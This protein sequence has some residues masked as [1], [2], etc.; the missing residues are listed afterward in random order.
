[1]NIIIELLTYFTLSVE[2]KTG[3]TV[4]GY[5]CTNKTKDM[6]HLVITNYQSI[7]CYSMT[8]RAHP[9]RPSKYFQPLPHI[10][11]A[12][13]WPLFES[14][15]TPWLLVFRAAPLCHEALGRVQCQ[16]NH[17]ACL[18]A[19]GKLLADYS[20]YRLFSVG[21]KTEV[22]GCWD[23]IWF[24]HGSGVLWHYSIYISHTSTPHSSHTTP[25]THI[26]SLTPHSYISQVKKF[27]D[28]K[29]MCKSFMVSF[30]L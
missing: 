6:H 14:N 2:L 11:L 3:C 5:T 24:N 15:C 22:I 30:H 26:T 29:N 13:T 25:L 8:T 17:G 16:R 1:M 28:E 7:V 4:S 9:A 21:S 10:I 27:C 19:V 12:C 18:Q 20:I 23:I